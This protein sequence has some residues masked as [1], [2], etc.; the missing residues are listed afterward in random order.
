MINHKPK[1]S[2]LVCS[3]YAA[4]LLSGGRPFFSIPEFFLSYRQAVL[5]ACIA[6]T[7]LRSTLKYEGIS[8]SL[9]QVMDVVQPYLTDED[10]IADSESAYYRD[11]SK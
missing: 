8:I 4:P 5:S 1:H 3:N 6:F 10:K 11:G 7:A 2:D 9:C